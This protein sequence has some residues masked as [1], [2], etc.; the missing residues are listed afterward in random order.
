MI[1]ASW[2]QTI[3]TL[4]PL[5]LSF[6]SPLSIVYTTWQ[7][8]MSNK[9]VYDELYNSSGK[10]GFKYSPDSLKIKATHFVMLLIL[11]AGPSDRAVWV[12]GLESLGA[13]IAGSNP[14]KRWMFILAC[15]VK[16][17]AL[18]RFGL[19][20]GVLRHVKMINNFRSTPELEQVT[21]PNPYR[22]RRWWWRLIRSHS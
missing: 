8:S 13:E 2:P 5:S 18:R 9:V 6:L 11:A 22:W 7:G 16:V 15:P 12:E 21:R 1:P 19:S 4:R 10:D 17:E 14:V 3:H 20:L